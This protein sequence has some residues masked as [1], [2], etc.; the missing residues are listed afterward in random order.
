MDPKRDTPALMKKYVKY[1]NASAR[2]LI[3]PDAQ[4]REAAAGWGV[5]YEYVD[6]KD[7]EYQVNHT[8]GT[9]LVDRDGN[10]RVV[11][12]YLQ[13]TTNPQRVAQ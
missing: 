8:T 11:W 3:I 10:R 13:L 6:E 7:G 5:G 1:F 2:G 9:Y 4:L 12:D